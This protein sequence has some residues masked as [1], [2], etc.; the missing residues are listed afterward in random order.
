MG[1]V[2]R[3]DRLPIVVDVDPE[4]SS[5]PGNH[6]LAVHDGRGTLDLEK[7][8]LYTHRPELVA[9]VGGGAMDILRVTSAVRIGEQLGEVPNDRYLVGLS[10][11]A[12]DLRPGLGRER[13]AGER[14]QRR[15]DH[16]S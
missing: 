2:G 7:F 1:P 11:R 9:D 13:D 16:N 10:E 15:E 5:G 8:R 14:D 12:G 4:R 3:I 6:Q